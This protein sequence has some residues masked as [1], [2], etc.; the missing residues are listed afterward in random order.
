MTQTHVPGVVFQPTVVRGMQRGIN[1][2]VNAVRPTLGPRARLVA[3]ERTTHTDTPEL[4]DSGGVIVRRVIELPDRDADA[5]AMFIRQLL[6][7]QHEREGD[8]VVTTAVIFQSLFNQGV[9]YLTSGGNAMQLRRYLEKGGQ[10]VLAELTKQAAPVEGQDAL[11]RVANT[12]CGEPELARLL[13]EIFD[14]IGEYGRLEVRTGRGRDLEREYV[15][16]IYWNSGALSWQMIADK[17]QGRAEL[18]S[19][20]ILISDLHIEEPDDLVPLLKVVAE[21]GIRSLFIIAGRMADTAI[22]LLMTNRNAGKLDIIAAKAPGISISD[23]AAAL[24]DLTY[25]TGGKPFADQAGAKLGQLRVEDLGRA[26]RAWVDRDYFGVVGGA[27]DPRA[28][29]EHIGRLRVAF[30]RISDPEERKKVRERIGKLMGGAATLWIGG[31]TETEM[32]VRKELAE[33]TAEAVRGAMLEGV[34]PGGGVALLACRQPLR[35]RLAQAADPDERAAY[36]ILLRALEEPARVLIANAGH[37]PSEMMAEIRLAGQGHGFDVQAER[38]VN[39]A[40]A[41]ILDAA[42]VLR[43]AVW[44]AVNGAG[45]ALTTGALV[46]RKKPYQT[47]NP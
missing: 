3:I 10:V 25:L 39:M 1:W 32:N 4:L 36:R 22:G 16:G 38:V 6:W 5:G 14:I 2:M 42:S 12:I 31:A 47:A 15:E 29:R 33:R 43:A 28:L 7:T 44:R 34:V 11:A 35:E 20:A 17:P 30:G 45:I 26:R 18:E 13:G 40:E 23:V 8:G 46:H 19:P 21:A 27:G 24:E 41:G 37:D 9:T